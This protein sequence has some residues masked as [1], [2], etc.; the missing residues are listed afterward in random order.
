MN[1]VRSAMAPETMVA[2]VAQN[3]RLNTK[4]DQ[5]NAPYPEKI[6]SVGLPRKTPMAL[7]PNMNP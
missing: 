2:V 4:V 6:S 3:T 7:S 1:L 5:S